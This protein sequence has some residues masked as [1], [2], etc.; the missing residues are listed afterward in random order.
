MS[1]KNIQKKRFLESAKELRDYLNSEEYRKYKSEAAFIR[2]YIYARFGIKQGYQIFDGKNDGGID[3]VVDA[4]R[5]YVIQSKYETVPKIK[6]VSRGEIAHF[7][8]LSDMFKV[9]TNQKDFDTWVS[10][11]KT[12]CRNEYIRV[13]ERALKDPDSVV[14]LFITTKQFNFTSTSVEVDDAQKTLAL[15]SL[16]QEGFTPPTQKISINIKNDWHYESKEFDFNTYVGLADVRDFLLIM[17]NDR[18]ERL[19]TQNVRTD[20]KS[21][22]NKNI[23]ETYEDHPHKFWLGNNGL[24]IVCKKVVKQGNEFT[25]TYP[26]IINGSQTLHSIFASK[27]RH[28]CD[29]LV[30][31]LEMDVIGNPKLL[32]EVVRRTNTQNAMKM[33][34]LVA[35]DSHQFN[36]AKFLDKYSIFYERREKEWMNEKKSI[37]TSYIPINLKKLAQWLAVT[38]NHMGLGKARS[39]VGSIFD[40]QY[41]TVF[42]QYDRVMNSK[43]YDQLLYVVWC[44]L[45]VQNLLKKLPKRTKPFLKISHLLFVKAFFE[46]LNKNSHFKYEI[47]NLMKNHR[48][49]QKIISRKIIKLVENLING[50]I[51]AQTHEAKNNPNLDFSNFFKIDNLTEKAYNKVFKLSLLDKLGSIMKADF[52]SII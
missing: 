52:S 32:N 47:E 39:Q 5:A 28:S 51:K 20:I 50:L 3:A 22:I 10:K 38:Q 49:G 16:Y 13:R 11:L 42:G 15:W 29:I 14:F 37:L 33:E 35:H 1:E 17:S 31:I 9:E 12:E 24:Y 36:I 21:K 45:F 6:D 2:W 30:R 18:N 34:N 48:F 23:R 27:A 19:F 46:V 43:K 4:D 8:R 25:L 7:E 41:I 44:G 26:S 40:T